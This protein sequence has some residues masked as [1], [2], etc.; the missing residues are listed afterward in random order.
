MMKTTIVRGFKTRGEAE[1]ALDYL[2]HAGFCENQL[3]IVG[4]GELPGPW[5]S[6]SAR[7]VDSADK[8]SVGGILT[9]STL[10]AVADAL[11]VALIPGIGP[12]AAGGILV[13]IV[14]GVAAGGAAG[15]FAGPFLRLGFSR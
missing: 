15:A 9:G 14:T 8:G 7:F 6:P 10:V 3:G 5:P 12:V 2:R 11:A 4:P 13:D 1:K